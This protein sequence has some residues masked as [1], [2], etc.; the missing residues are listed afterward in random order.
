M[1]NLYEIKNGAITI[2]VGE[3]RGQEF[4]FKG[5]TVDNAPENYYV[6]YHSSYDIYPP[7]KTVIEIGKYLFD[8]YKTEADGQL[9]RYIEDNIS[10]YEFY[11]ERDEYNNFPFWSEI[12]N[13]AG[14]EPT[15]KNPHELD[16][17]D[18]MNGFV[19]LSINGVVC[20]YSFTEYKTVEYTYRYTRDKPI[21]SAI[22][23]FY[24]DK[25]LNELL[26]L[27]QYRRGIA[28]PAYME[29]VKLRE[30]LHEKK[31]VKLVMKSG[32]VY[33]LKKDRL[34]VRDILNMY[35]SG[36]KLCFN[37]NNSYYLRPQ[38]RAVQPLSELD[39]L[40]YGK[41]KHYI[42]E[43]NLLQYTKNKEERA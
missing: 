43:Q 14:I 42:S 41:N 21:E 5:F 4:A 2:Y 30:F 32:L 10:R 24:R 34:Y 31:S 35:I 16:L 28:V 18:V 17:S 26:A 6:T 27:E 25:M 20:K 40:Q 36:D 3:M 12:L 9:K 29:L 39:Y 8:L 1:K 23:I 7:D 11:A 37:L 38:M 15:M 19:G 13:T 33:D 22:E